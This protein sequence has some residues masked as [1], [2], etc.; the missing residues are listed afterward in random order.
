[1]NCSYFPRIS[2][3]P[4][5]FSDLDRQLLDRYI[6]HF[7]KTYPTFTGP[8]NPFLRVLIPPSMQSRPVLDAMLALCCVQS[9]ENGSFAMEAPMLKY[10]C[11]AIRGC[12]DLV[13]HIM[14]TPGTLQSRWV[15]PTL[16]EQAQHLQDPGRCVG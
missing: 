13:T 4:F 1:M 8:K 16:A 2:A 10:R 12:M 15:D 7:S 14:G 5:S 6:Q 9:W 3:W 11:K